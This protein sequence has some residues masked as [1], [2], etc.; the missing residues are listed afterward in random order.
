MM[1]PRGMP[2]MPGPRPYIA[3]LQDE[4]FKNTWL[5]AA[6]FSFPIPYGPMGVCYFPSFY[7]FFKFAM[8]NRGFRGSRGRG[9]RG[10][11]GGRS[12]DYQRRG[13]EKKENERQSEE[14]SHEASPVPST[15]ENNTP[16]PPVAETQSTA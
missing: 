5:D 4:R 16:A 1:Y 14:H 8:D 13:G 9:Y 15:T 3:N 2:F 7:I 11:R 6:A 12:G 10:S